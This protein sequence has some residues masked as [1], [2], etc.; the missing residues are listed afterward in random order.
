MFD[1]WY[2]GKI[3]VHVFINMS[4]YEMVSVQ[5][6]SFYK[7]DCLFTKYMQVIVTFKCLW[8]YKWLYRIFTIDENKHKC[9]N[10]FSKSYLVHFKLC[11]NHKNSFL[12]PRFWLWQCQF[13]K[14]NE[15]KLMEKMSCVF[16]MMPSINWQWISREHLLFILQNNPRSPL[17]LEYSI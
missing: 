13:N 16:H 3:H 12:F 10:I 15:E 11:L 6:G 17:H 4:I 8:L 7:W 2:M 1:M 14:R 9:T 5:K